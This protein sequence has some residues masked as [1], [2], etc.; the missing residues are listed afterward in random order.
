M[1]Y[2]IAKDMAVAEYLEFNVQ[3]IFFITHCWVVYAKILS[4]SIH[5][6]YKLHHNMRNGSLFDQENTGFG[7]VSEKSY[8]YV[9]IVWQLL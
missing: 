3:S 7:V 6:V 5:F 8:I 1:L 2:A 4:E 9:M